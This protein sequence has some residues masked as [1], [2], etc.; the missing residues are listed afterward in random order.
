M[1]TNLD[2]DPG[3]LE[4]VKDAGHYRTKREAVEAALRLHLDTLRPDPEDMERRMRSRMVHL[5]LLPFAAAGERKVKMSDDAHTV[6]FKEYPFLRMAEKA[7]WV[8]YHPETGQT[9]AH[10]QITDTGWRAVL[11]ESL[12]PESVDTHGPGVTL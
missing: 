10:Y 5:V 3:L 2:I 4:A 1:A 11:E 7:G 9:K 8:T 6:F 12:L